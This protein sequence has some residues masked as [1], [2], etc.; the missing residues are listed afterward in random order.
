MYYHMLRHL[1]PYVHGMGYLIMEMNY[2]V[3]HSFLIHADILTSRRSNIQ[4]STLSSSSNFAFGTPVSLS[5]PFRPPSLRRSSMLTLA[6]S[7]VSGIIN[8]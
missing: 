6:S 5:A 1:L 7:C 3:S 8:L 4:K 2:L